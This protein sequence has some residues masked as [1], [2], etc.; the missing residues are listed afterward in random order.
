[1]ARS[2]KGHSATMGALHE[3]G[4]AA[5]RLAH[6]WRDW[7][8]ALPP[9]RDGFRR[10]LEALL[11]RA[12]EGLIAEH[13][14]AELPA[15]RP[16][17][18]DTGVRVA[19]GDRVTLVSAGRVWL[20]LRLDLWT[21]PSFQLWARVGKDGRILRGT[22]DTHTFTADGDGAL[23]LASHP[24]GEWADEKGSL[25][26]PAEE[27]AAS[28]GGLTVLAIRWAC[29]PE[30]GLRA[31]AELGAD[32]QD[33]AD[34]EHTLRTRAYEEPDFTLGDELLKMRFSIG[35][36]A[37]RTPEEVGHDFE[38][39]REALLRIKAKLERGLHGLEAKAERE[40]R[41]PLRSHHL[42]S[43]GNYGLDS[44]HAYVPFV[45]E[46][47]RLAERDATP[48]GWRYLWF[49]GPAEIYRLERHG[50]R[51]AILCHT[52]GDVGILQ[53]DVS[54]PLGDE[55][56]L[57]W[58]WQ[59]E[60]LPSSLP[61]DTALS[62]DYLSI[63]VEFE[64]GRDITYTWSCSLPPETGYACP[65]P[66]WTARETHVVVRSGPELLGH[67]LRE[68]RDL[69][70]DYARFIGEPPERIVR[71]WLIANSLFQRREGVCRYAD[72]AIADAAGVHPI[73]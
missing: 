25:A 6:V 49:L 39:T 12:P 32:R 54:L 14:F 35:E 63:A 69:R 11:A 64:N 9:D 55:T 59:V 26:T 66:N 22:R 37:N 57:C 10:R 19:K 16:P 3:L 29:E 2:E 46:L 67:W 13:T 50:G 15:D 7:G 38:A 70:A 62:H 17:W 41:R 58:Y 20:S 8:G 48:D 5:R 43:F 27:Y 21:P 40:P 56:R 71:V 72:I 51:D 33:V 4:I 61:E 60:R 73:A 47:A 52:R 65:L 23:H 68:E 44:L 18:T 53:R 36:R 31:L 1:M 42:E 34:R 45:R 24:P 28:E 30:A